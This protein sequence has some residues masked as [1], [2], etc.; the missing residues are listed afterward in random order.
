MSEVKCL[1]IINS[2]RNSLSGKR[3]HRIHF[4]L[5]IDDVSH[6][7]LSSFLCSVEIFTVFFVVLRFV[8]LLL[9]K[10]KTNS[11]H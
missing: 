4:L 5:L 10:S 11:E 6:H 9:F 1:S 3:V 2:K 7:T 8:L